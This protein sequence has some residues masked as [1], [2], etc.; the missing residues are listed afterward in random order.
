MAIWTPINTAATLHWTQVQEA[1][2]TPSASE[3][4][5][6][7]D[8]SGFQT[9]TLT[10]IRT[11]SFN[12]AVTV[13]RARVYR[14]RVIHGSFNLDIPVANGG[15]AEWTARRDALMAAKAE[16]VIAFTSD[17]LTGDLKYEGAY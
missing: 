10:A 6:D 15:G 3:A 8:G 13:G 4:V 5:L 14:Y 7:I 17:A 2:W 1:S 11:L 12:G 9:T 16:Y